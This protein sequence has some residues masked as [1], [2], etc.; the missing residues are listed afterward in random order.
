[1]TGL[2][3]PVVSYALGL[4]ALRSLDIYGH[5]TY[6]VVVHF[7][8]LLFSGLVFWI[9]G[10]FYYLGV[11][12][13]ALPFSRVLTTIHMIVT[14]LAFLGFGARQWSQSVAGDLFLLSAG[15]FLVTAVL[16]AIA[17]KRQATS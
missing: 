16:A 2:L 6:F 12:L 8:L 9:Y 1:V 15:L 10:C 17:K 13:F 11:R 7:R 4:A 14:A 5:D 3:F